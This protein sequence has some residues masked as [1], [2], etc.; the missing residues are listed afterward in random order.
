M[1]ETKIFKPV[2]KV[3]FFHIL[4][5]LQNLKSIISAIFGSVEAAGGVE[6]T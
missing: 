6:A 2:K 5:V 4:G 3:F 1:I